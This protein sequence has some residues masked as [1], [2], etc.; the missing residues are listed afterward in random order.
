MCRKP[1]ALCHYPASILSYL[2]SV[3]AAQQRLGL[4]RRGL[5][6][7]LQ[8][9][10]ERVHNFGFYFLCFLFGCSTF[11]QSV[12]QN[13]EAQRQSRDDS[14]SGGRTH[15]YCSLSLKRSYATPWI[16]CRHL[17][18]RFVQVLSQWFYAP[19]V[20]E[21]SSHQGQVKQTFRIK[22]ILF[23]LSLNWTYLMMKGCIEV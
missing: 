8:H 20:K 14:P 22:T 11:S 16:L 12:A 5:P 3:F 17:D 6:T 13:Q 18:A 9:C 1:V 15:H 19:S 7:H 2:M 23:C 10:K 4:Q 21:C